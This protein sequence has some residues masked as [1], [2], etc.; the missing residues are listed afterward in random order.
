MTEIWKP[1]PQYPGYEAS[2]IGNVRSVDRWIKSRHGTPMF[3][4]GQ[5]LK[6]RK[7]A[8]G[9]LRVNLS[10]D[11]NHSTVHVHQL[12]ISAFRGVPPAGMET[13]H[14]NGNPKDNRI[15]N[16]RYGTPKENQRDMYLHG[17]HPLVFR[18]HCPKGHPFDEENTYR[19]PG[20]PTTR[21]CKACDRETYLRRR[22]R[23]KRKA[24]AA[25]GETSYKLLNIA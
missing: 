1:V 12:V 14:N 13:C 20:D 3:R 4:K 19:P 24:H 9:H 25:T 18:T 10:V 22:D 21:R 16:L 5:I 17:T 6:Q 2:N 11:G 7:R 8:S 15:E 23:K